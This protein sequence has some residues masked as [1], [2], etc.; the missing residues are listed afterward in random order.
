MTETEVLKERILKLASDIGFQD[1][2]T[3]ALIRH[4]VSEFSKKG[5]GA[6]YY[7]YHNIQHE[8][9]AAYFTLIAA[10]DHYK[11]ENN[12]NQDDLIYLF[13]AALFHDYDPMKR[14]DKP[15]EDSVEMFVRNDKRIKKYIDNVGINI[16]IVFALIHRTAYPFRDNIAKHANLRIQELFT[17]AGITTNDTKT[18]EHY[19]YLGW[20]LS[21]SER[22]A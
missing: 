14:F 1:R 22:I 9:E 5:L 15:H 10:Y 3:S 7:G 6:D 20:F 2:W 8:L 17:L 13:V 21:I 4:A 16:D 18:R 11:L 19:K 12:F